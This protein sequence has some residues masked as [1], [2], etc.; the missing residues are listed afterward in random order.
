MP[1]GHP[2]PRCGDI[3]VSIYELAS[4]S[5]NDNCLMEYFSFGVTLTMRVTNTSL[6]RVGDSL[7]A[8]KLA[9][10]VGFN[11]RAEQLRAFLHMAWGI[12]GDANTLIN[13]LTLS[14]NIVYGF[15][16]PARYRGMEAPVLVGGEWFSAVPEAMDMG[17]KAEM[18]FEDARRL[19][20]IALFV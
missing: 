11:S 13:D 5:T 10:K 18:R 15:A 9:K 12:I 19:Q 14:G 2:P 6:D 4:R 7:L 17:I 1:D 8:R 20:P 16:E 3:F